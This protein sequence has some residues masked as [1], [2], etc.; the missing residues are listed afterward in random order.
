MILCFP[1][2]ALWLSVRLLMLYNTLELHF[3][4]KIFVFNVQLCLMA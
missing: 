1:I 3:A 4:Q 2:L